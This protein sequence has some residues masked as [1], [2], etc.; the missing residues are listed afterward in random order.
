MKLTDFIN[1]KLS[2]TRQMN[3]S[4]TVVDKINYSNR[5]TFGTAMKDLAEKLKK[6]T[7]TDVKSA[8]GGAR[9]ISDEDRTAI[10]TVLNAIADRFLVLKD[11]VDEVGEPM[12]DERDMLTLIEDDIFNFLGIEDPADA[13]MDLDWR[14]TERI[15]NLVSKNWDNISKAVFGMS[16]S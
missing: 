5:L 12:G 3:E 10:C 6:F 1:E 13:D 4:R 8:F 2:E 14:T 16:W 9:Q 15:C 11:N 7:E